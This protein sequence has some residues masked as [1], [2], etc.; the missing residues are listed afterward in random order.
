MSTKKK[1]EDPQAQELPSCFVIMPIAD[2]EG[3]DEGHFKHVYEDI[4][5]PGCENAGFAP[6]RADDVKQTNMIHVDI[7]NR[8]IQA[9]MAVC[10]LSSRN[11]NVLFE[12]GIRQAFDKP[13]VLIQEKG[14]KKI[15][16]ISPLRFLEY[17]S[18][19]KYHE[20]KKS[21]LELTEMIKATRDSQ[22]KAE[23]INSIIKLLSISGPAR[24]P[25][26]PEDQEK[27]AFNY[28]RSEI[29]DLQ[30]MVKHLA[31]S[32]SSEVKSIAAVEYER[33]SSRL[34]RLASG[35]LRVPTEKRRMELE[36]LFEESREL[37][38]MAESTKEHRMF[39][40]LSHRIHRQMNEKD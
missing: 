26:L 21:Q 35:R 11:P 17:S 4:I 37:S 39:E 7:L 16:D 2:P 13:T 15:F 18:E 24:I 31:M 20:V 29:Q 23:S 34:D 38:H 30:S 1:T 10:D 22:G 3:Y 19:M 40:H 6:V 25:D 27:I 36:R 33:L 28:L 14:T 8:L 12:L 5:T 9:P 32:K